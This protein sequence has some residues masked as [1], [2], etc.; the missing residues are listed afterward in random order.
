MS[1]YIDITTRKNLELHVQT[2][3]ERRGQQVQL[4]TQVSQSIAAADSFEDLYQRVVNQVKEQFG[5]YHTQL[6]RYDPTQE[7]VCVGNR[8]R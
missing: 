2:A 3:F 4:S 5:Y 8:L 7:V 1:T 6:L